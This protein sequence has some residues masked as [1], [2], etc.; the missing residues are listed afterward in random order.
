M[1]GIDT[2]LPALATKI[3]IKQEDAMTDKEPPPSHDSALER[4]PTEFDAI[5]G[6]SSG[7]PRSKPGPGRRSRTTAY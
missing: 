4:E 6:G 2:G 3:R 5:E 7:W 1:V